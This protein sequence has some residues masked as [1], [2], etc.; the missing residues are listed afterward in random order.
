MAGKSKNLIGQKFNRLTVLE[1]TG[2]RKNGSVVWLCKCDCGNICE[3][4][5]GSLTRTNRPTKSCGCLKKETDHAPKGNVID[6][7]NQIFGHLIVIQRDGS[8]A[9]GEAKWLCKCDCGN[10]NLISVLGSNLRSGH[11]QSCGCERRSHG[12]LKVAQ[13]LNDNN[14]SFIQ[15]YRPFKFAS[16]KA[17]SFD[18]YVNN[19]YIIEYDGE[20][21]YQYNLHG[22][23]TKEQLEAQ[24][25]RDIIKN[26]WC[27]ENNIPLIRIPYTHL[28]DLCIEDLQLETSHFIVE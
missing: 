14:I 2:K 12:E 19:Q 17:A 16:G 13:I 7:T 8:D 5:G 15:E 4:N 9:R 24:Q 1:D 26:Q 28:K 27:K 21:H 11:T 23:H 20:T 6:L 10:P 18:F 25:E 22:W 3:I